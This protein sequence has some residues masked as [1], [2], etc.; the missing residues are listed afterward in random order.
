MGAS[1]WVWLEECKIVRRTDKAIL[2]KYDGAEY[3]IPDSQM[4]DPEAYRSFKDGEDG[5][6]IGISEWIANEKGIEA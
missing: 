3:W 1:N 6:T 4:D 2:I 5:I